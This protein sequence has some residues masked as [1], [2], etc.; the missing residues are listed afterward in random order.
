MRAM[1]PVVHELFSGHAFALRDLRFVVRKNVVH[2][3][4]M[5]V[6][7]IAQNRSRHRAALDMPAWTA[8]APWRIPFYV[9]IV[10]VPRLPECEIA[11]VFLVILVVFDPAGGLQ[12]VEIEMRELS[13]V[14]KLIDP[15]INRF[16]VGLISETF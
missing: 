9:A 7:L 15:I 3:A 5:D 12:F 2:P 16:V 14:R 1:Q 8:R 13:V 11:D 10:F 4:A 6:D